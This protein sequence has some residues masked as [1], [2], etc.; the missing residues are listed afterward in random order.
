MMTECDVISWGP[1]ACIS[2]HTRQ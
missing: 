2:L 1:A